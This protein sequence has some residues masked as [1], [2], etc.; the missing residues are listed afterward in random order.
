MGTKNGSLPV[1]SWVTPTHLGY[2]KTGDRG[3]NQRPQATEEGGGNWEW[4][5]FTF[6]S[7]WESKVILR[8]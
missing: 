7:D 8:S 3:E 6:G 4:D 1:A 2:K 5:Y